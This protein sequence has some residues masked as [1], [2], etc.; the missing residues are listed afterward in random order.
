MKFLTILKNFFKKI[1][2]KEYIS[3]TL[4][5]IIL[6]LIIFNLNTCNKLKHEKEIN[7]RI[8]MMNDNNLKAMTDTLKVYFDK[9]LNAVVTE[10][11]SY[12]IDDIKD[13][14]KYNEGLYDEF[15][16]VKGMIAGIKGDLRGDLQ[17]L[18]NKLDGVINFDPKDSLYNMPWNFTYND[19]GFNYNVWGNSRFNIVNGLPKYPRSILDSTTF[20]ISLKYAIVEN[21]DHYTVRAY[22]ESNKISFTELEGVANIKKTSPI[23][24]NHRKLF[25]G[26]VA[27][28]GLNTNVIGKDSRFGWSVGFGIGYNILGPKNK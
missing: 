8:T 19:P 26:P 27:S 5:V 16:D 18:E 10:K 3:L 13:L 17:N 15:K 4:G 11:T 9:Q 14:K 2:S 25:I 20:K 7:E 1:F 22:T 6:L 12:V 23:L 28:F 21:D 24:N